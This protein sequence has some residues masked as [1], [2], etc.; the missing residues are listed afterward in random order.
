MKVWLVVMICQNSVSVDVYSTKDAAGKVAAELR[1]SN[2]QC[3]VGVV[4]TTVE[5]VQQ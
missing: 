4:D 5:G 2:L 1:A 3:K